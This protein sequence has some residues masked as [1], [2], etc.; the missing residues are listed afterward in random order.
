MTREQA[1]NVYDQERLLNFEER[2]RLP[3][4]QICRCVGDMDIIDSPSMTLQ[5][6]RDADHGG[7]NGLEARQSRLEVRAYPVGATQ[8]FFSSA[9]W[10]RVG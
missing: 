10:G 4:Q 7:G 2:R 6:P 3:E 8:I 1:S 5:Q 9:H